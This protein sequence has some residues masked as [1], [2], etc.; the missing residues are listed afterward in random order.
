MLAFVITIAI[1]AVGAFLFYRMKVPAGAVV[2]AILLVS[3]FQVVTGLAIFP[4]WLKVAVQAVAGGFVGQRITR[5]DVQ[6]FHG[7]IRP[8]L[9]LF[10][11]IALFSVVTGALIHLTTP[12][13]SVS[14]A[15][16]AS[17]PGG[18]SDVVLLASDLNADPTQASVLQL[19]RYL[20]AIVILPQVA[21]RLCRRFAPSEPAKNSSVQS[22]GV[23]RNSVFS[24]AVTLG[25]VA[26]TGYLG[27]RSGFPAGAMI[28]PMFSLAAYNIRTGKAYLPK[29][30]KLGAQCFAGI[31]IGVGVTMADVLHLP[32]LAL[33]GLLVVI[34]CLSINYGL[35]L[36][37]YRVSRLDLPTCL[38]SAIPAGLSDMALISADLG[39]DPPKVALMQLTRFLCVMTFMPC[40]IKLLS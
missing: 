35:G 20:V 25:I 7:L 9:T 34:N 24:V 1:G 33:P 13:I 29:P 15:L 16:L 28:L 14:T 22:S 36:L 30:V 19:I 39:G 10:S 18:M 6:E 32:E 38:F 40:V 12:S 11:G 8:A 21:T 2:G 23:P 5:Q 17:V 4:R 27:R 37:L 3:I 31:S 26:V